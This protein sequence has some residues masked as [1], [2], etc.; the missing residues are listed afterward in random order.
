MSTHNQRRPNIPTALAKACNRLAAEQSKA[1][2]WTM[3]QDLR[4]E[5][6][7]RLSGG[8]TLADL[9][10]DIHARLLKAMLEQFQISIPSEK[11][12]RTEFPNASRYPG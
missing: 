12:A 3:G 2:T 11:C 6:G 7:R 10:A 1:T 8:E 4:N 9:E 5:Y